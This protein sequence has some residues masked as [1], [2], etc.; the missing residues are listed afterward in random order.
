MSSR[1]HPEY[2]TSSH[3]RCKQYGIRPDQVYSLRFAEGDALF[4]R[5][6]ALQEFIRVAEPFLNHLYG[7]VKGSDF[8]VVLTDADGCILNL[9]GDEKIVTEAYSYKMIP[10]AFMNEANIGT[11]AMGT[12][13]AE[14]K[15]LQVSGAQHFI[16]AYHRW[17]CS[18]CPIHNRDGSILGILDLTGYSA[19][20]HPHTLGMVVAAANAIERML[21]NISF[22]ET[23]TLEKRQSEAII[24]SI[25]V[26]I[27]S[28]DLNGNIRMANQHASDMFGYSIQELCRA[29]AFELFDGWDQ[30]L[31][32]ARVRTALIDEEVTVH[33]RRNKVRYTLSTYPI[34]GAGESLHGLVL[35]IKEV[36]KVRKLANRIMGQK[37]IYTF[38]KMIGQDTR[39]LQLIDYAK[40][41]S[42]SR[43]TILITGESGTGKELFAQAIHNQSNRA[44]EAFVAVHCGALPFSQI[45]EQLFGVSQDGVVS[46]ETPGKI[47]IADGG[48]LYLDE[49]DEMPLEMQSQLLKLIEGGIVTRTDGHIDM[50]VDVRVIASC[51]RSIDDAVRSGKL[52]KDL[53]YRLN[54]LPLHLL[55]L[56]ERRSDIP[57]LLNHFLNRHAD[58]LNKRVILPT[59]SDITALM[60]Y[61]WP[62]NIRELENF[63]ALAINTESMPLGRLLGDNWH[64][65]PQGAISF[66]IP[67]EAMRLED[68]ERR[69]IRHV[70]ERFSGNVAA[71][72]RS[73]GISRNTL[74]RKLDD[75]MPI[76]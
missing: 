18:A 35:V 42:D 12:A 28:T 70:L 29:K 3:E 59:E 55:A 7:F 38:E 58:R 73:L 69:Y 20:V 76:I 43:S 68:F 9:F 25:T 51:S 34:F 26:G 19:N 16:G 54:V 65:A 1:H 13:L 36:H 14:N 40:K 22:L 6:Q 71:A 46:N 32:R 2:I 74:Y 66:E 52:R 48:T 23:I 24:E 37:A 67:L 4:Q 53:F 30:V 72:A 64:E 47:A 61:D 62:G 33:A 63:A 5:L 10:G 15:P 27:M 39:F 45:E 44:E 21:E 41:I 8:F 60:A 75:Q 49:I 57:L 50:V 56:R 11:N 17:T 31:E